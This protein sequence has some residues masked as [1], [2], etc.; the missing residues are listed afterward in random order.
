MNV[1]EY[2]AKLQEDVQ[3]AADS[4]LSNPHDEFLRIV[5]GILADAEE[6]D[7]FT[8]CHFEGISDLKHPMRIDGYS[9]DETDGICS[10]FISNYYGEFDKKHEKIDTQT[11]TNLSEQL[12]T[13]VGEAIRTE[14]YKELEE[15]TQVYEFSKFLHCNND[16]ILSFR[17]YI[18]TDAIKEHEDIKLRAKTVFDKKVD[19]EIWDIQRIFNV[20]NSINQKDSVEIDIKEMGFEGIPCVQAVDCKDVVADI[21]TEKSLDNTNDEKENIITYTSYLAVVP[22]TVL[23]ELYHTYGAKLLEG[24]VRSFL[25]AKGKVNKSIQRTIIHYPEM[26][27]A[28]NN[29][30]A[31]TAS[32]I[33][34]EMTKKGLVITKLKDLQIV[35]GGQTTASITNTVLHARKDEHVDLSKLFV[36]MKVSVLEHSMSEKII[37]KISEYSNSQN[38]VDASDFF[39]NHPFHK[40]M[41]EFS[42]NTPAPIVK[43]NQFHQYWF[44]ER[45]R[46]QY[47]QGMMK[48]KAKSS[49]L[50]QYEQKYPKNQVIKMVDLAKYMEIYDAKPHIVSK[51]KQALVRDFSA[52]I[53]SSW[54][55]SDLPF[56][57]YYFRRVVAIAIMFNELDEIVKNT[58]WYQIRHS[59]KANIVAYTLSLVFAYIK[60]QYPG[61]TIDF[62]KIWNKQTMYDELK[63][64][65]TILSEEIYTYITRDD[66]PIENVTEWCKSSECW[67]GALNHSWSFTD[68]FINSLID[69][70]S[71][72]EEID[73]AKK[74]QKVADEIKDMEF[75]LASGQGYWMDVL[76]WDQDRKVLTEM[77]ISVIHQII[78]GFISGRM[79]SEKQAKV[80]MKARKRLLDN[81][82]PLE[83]T[84][85]NWKNIKD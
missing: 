52:D 29:G 76:K 11:I 39:S 66:R 36:P 50:S 53:K 42:R 1:E 57:V 17:L 25:S 40:R 18:L 79:V 6:F 74:T 72:T 54:E 22:G 33:E 82:M 30:I 31:A 3:L 51:G 48:F 28:Y 4:N 64:Q 78:R 83:F 65:V 56:N 47:L 5:T 20:I 26:F 14:L 84:S 16:D 13:F 85:E 46:G 70:S 10:V 55:K 80:A 71:L 24:N 37:P 58:K 69:E 73:E 62:S 43:G 7:D 59:Y 35:N 32:H 44:Y 2:R 23:H 15:S 67:K 21:E 63:E 77:E 81:G 61:K 60:A 19:F 12:I 9:I 49:E 27:F 75:I 8:N 34:T 45:M 38:K 41:E 68:S